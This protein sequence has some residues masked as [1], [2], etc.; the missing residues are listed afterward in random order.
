M[1][2]SL[3]VSERLRD[4]ASLITHMSALAELP[5]AYRGLTRDEIRRRIRVARASL[6]DS[7]LVLVHN[8]QNDEVYEWADRTGDS[9][10]LSVDAKKSTA[11]HIIF[12][13]VTFMAETA[14]VVTG[15]E[16]NILIPSME[17]SCP[18]AG[19]AEMIQVRAAWKKWTSV[20][21]EETLRPV[22][23][24]NSYA[25]LKAFTGEKG[26]L[27][28]T[29]SN[30]QKAFEWAWRADPSAK[31]VFLPDKHL[32]GNTAKWLGVKDEDIVSWSPWN[33]DFGGTTPEAFAKARVVLWE[34]FCQVHDRFKLEHVDEMREAY[35]G[36]KIL[37][38]PECRREV[39][40]ASDLSGSTSFII[41][42]VEKSAPGSKWAIGTEIHLVKRLAREH[43]DKTIVQLCGKICLDCNAMRQVQSEYLL[44]TLEEL[45]EGRIV[46]RIRVADHD[47][48]GAE[49][50]LNRMLEL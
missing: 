35:P 32:G 13:G 19:M 17:A 30:S 27:V 42:A 7:T 40:E 1:A 49:L 46:N 5:P 9:Y 2:T 12:C 11:R 28:C 15:G 36:I 38:H 10:Q 29:S 3:A 6:G 21:S 23:Y 44:W 18:M 33:P 24:M 50:A 41:D 8:Y 4:E 48:P 45:V 22:T 14:D 20:V 25:D 37:V 26:G 43:P 39:V 16:R 31:L 47:R 34:G